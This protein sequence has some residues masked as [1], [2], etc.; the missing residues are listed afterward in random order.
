MSLIPL[1]LFIEVR[2]AEL[3]LNIEDT[4][5]VFGTKKRF[6][7]QM[8]FPNRAILR[9]VLRLAYRLHLHPLTLIEEYDMGKLMI[10]DED[11]AQLR[12]HYRVNPDPLTALRHE[13]LTTK[14]RSPV[15]ADED[16]GANP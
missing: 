4:Y 12:E 11:R 2:H 6:T 3:G 10:T 8:N 7:R 16:Q 13:R 14:S 15:F 9:D 5:E 1:P